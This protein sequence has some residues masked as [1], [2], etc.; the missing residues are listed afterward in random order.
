MVVDG[1]NYRQPGWEH[2]WNRGNGKRTRC[3]SRCQP[4]MLAIPGTAVL[5][6]IDLRRRHVPSA[7][8]VTH[9]ASLSADAGLLS[10]GSVFTP[11]LQAIGREAKR[12]GEVENTQQGSIRRGK[13]LAPQ[14]AKK[15]FLE[16]FAGNPYL[17]GAV[18]ATKPDVGAP[19]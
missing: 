12:A 17:S 6:R 3:E 16:L 15:M 9:A 13:N 10:P 14:L 8:N 4:P 2:V 18:L 5:W 7:K 11:S 1:T 19:L